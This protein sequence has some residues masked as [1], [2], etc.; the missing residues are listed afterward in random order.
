MYI[1][2]ANQ[3]LTAWVDHKRHVLRSKRS[4]EIEMSEPFQECVQSV[5]LSLVSTCKDLAPASNKFT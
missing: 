4:K 1:K 2:D 3:S 5:C